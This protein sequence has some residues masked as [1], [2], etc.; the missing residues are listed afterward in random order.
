[1]G[2]GISATSLGCLERGRRGQGGWGRLGRGQARRCGSVWQ[3]LDPAI[4]P[5]SRLRLLPRVRELAVHPGQAVG[6][7]LAA[8]L[9]ASSLFPHEASR[10]RSAHSPLPGLPSDSPSPSRLQTKP[11]PPGRPQHSPPVLGSLSL[12]PSLSSEEVA[13]RAAA[14]HGSFSWLGVGSPQS[15]RASPGAAGH[16][17][18]QPP[19]T[20]FPERE[21]QPS[22]GGPGG[23]TSADTAS[24]HRAAHNS[25][26]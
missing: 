4:S 15:Q 20:P 10:A 18:A 5:V 2:I 7:L 26:G 6:T 17:A 13:P 3:S 14:P 23:F 25:S 11:E 22:Q 12:T 8:C 19:P 21:P 1:M 9:P 16:S 24:D